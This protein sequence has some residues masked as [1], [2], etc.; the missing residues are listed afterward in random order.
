[1]YVCTQAQA[2]DSML[3]LLAQ[4]ACTHSTGL[5]VFITM[6]NIDDKIKNK[7]EY[8]NLFKNGTYRKFKKIKTH[9]KL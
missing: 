4:K 1:M 7:E 9:N 8:L 6:N 3:N 2:F 5:K